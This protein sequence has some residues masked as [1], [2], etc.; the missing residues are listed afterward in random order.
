MQLLLVLLG[1]T[2]FLVLQ[3]SSL[4]L[5]QNC[6]GRPGWGGVGGRQERLIPGAKGCRGLGQ[7]LNCCFIH[8]LLLRDTR[9]SSRQVSD[10]FPRLCALPAAPSHPVQLSQL[11]PTDAAGSPGPGLWPEHRS[12][13]HVL[14]G[15]APRHPACS[16]P[17]SSPLCPPPAAHGSA[18]GTKA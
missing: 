1:P 6:L 12:R 11:I 5:N 14:R 15:A 16:C 4:Q 10:S 3:P 13:L 7:Q 18:A 17:H 8:K 2:F 9:R